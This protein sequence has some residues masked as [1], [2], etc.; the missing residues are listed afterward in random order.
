MNKTTILRIRGYAYKQP[1]L[2][3]SETQIHGHTPEQ[4]IARIKLK[5]QRAFPATKAPHKSGQPK[6]QVTSF[7]RWEKNG[8]ISFTLYD[9]TPKEVRMELRRVL[10]YIYAPNTATAQQGNAASPTGGNP[11]TAGDHGVRNDSQRTD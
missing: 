1:Y 10:N 7:V 3:G 2:G 9:C 4:I 6:V 11:P 8:S 5:M